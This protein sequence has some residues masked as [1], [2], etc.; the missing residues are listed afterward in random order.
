VV[1]NLILDKILVRHG[2]WS[3]SADGIFSEGIHLISGNVGSGK[4]TLASILIGLK[5]VDQ[6]TV[7]YDGI[8]SS[9]IS[10][11]FPEY[12][13]T[14]STLTEECKSWGLD[15]TSLLTSVNMEEKKDSAPLRLSR[16]E[17]KRLHLACIF[18]KNYD[19]LL[20]DEPFSSLDCAE[21]VRVCS[22]ISRQ[23]HGITLI[24]THE[25]SVFPAV[26][27]IWEIRDGV[28]YCLGAPPDAY[29]RW[30]SAPRIVK[31]LIADGKFPENISP[32][33]LLEAAWRT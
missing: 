28:L 8:I 27:R 32:D 26:D 24:F 25:Q 4:S 6:G 21:K 31:Q 9:M 11:Q 3:L 12:H 13:I 33:H 16:G 18:A 30:T 22:S 1:I 2:T 5:K 20:L 29:S 10:F 19:L 17:L 7:R 15:P 14:G 23:S